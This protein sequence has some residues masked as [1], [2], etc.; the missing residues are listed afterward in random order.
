[1]ESMRRAWRAWL[2]N[3]LSVMMLACF[4]HA[5]RPSIEWV[6]GGE[7]STYIGFYFQDDRY[8]V[9]SEGFYIHFWRLSDN[10]LVRTLT[11][12]QL[13]G[14][15]LYSASLAPM[16]NRQQLVVAYPDTDPDTGYRGI[17]IR[18]LQPDANLDNWTTAAQGGSFV[19]DGTEEDEP[20]NAAALA[21]SPDGQ[22]IAVGGGDAAG[23]TRHG[24]VLYRIN[25]NQIERVQYLTRDPGWAPIFAAAFSPDG[26]W[27]FAGSTGGWVFVYKR[28]PDGTYAYHQRFIIGGNGFY[29]QRFSFTYRP[30]GKYV[31]V[32][33]MPNGI[34]EIRR[35]NPVFNDWRLYMQWQTP[36]NS[37]PTSAVNDLQFT[38]DGNYLAAAYGSS[39]FGVI[40]YDP[41]LRIYQIQYSSDP[42][43]RAAIP[44]M[45][46]EFPADVATV[47][48]YNANATE[49]I[50]STRNGDLRRWN[51]ETQEYT[52]LPNHRGRLNTLAWS[53]N[54]AKIATAADVNYSVPAQ[55]FIWDFASQSVQ[56]RI[57]HPTASWIGALAFSPNGNYIATV[58]RDLSYDEGRPIEIWDANTGDWVAFAG[59]LSYNGSGLAFSPDG[60]YLYAAARNGELKAFQ[61]GADWQT[62]TEIAQTNAPDNA[63]TPVQIA[64]SPDGSRLAVGS[65]QYVQ[66][67]RT[68]YLTLDREI[69]V[70]PA[71]ERI[72]SVAWSPDGRYIA[73]G[74]REVQPAP[75]YL[76]S[77]GDWSVRRLPTAQNGYE[78][79]SVSFTPD[80]CYVL[81]AGSQNDEGSGVN[82]MLW[83]TGSSAL[84]AQYNDET[85][86][87]IQA[88]A[89]S[90]DGR[91]IAY[92]RDDGS[93]V[94]ANN[95]FYRRAGDV[96]RD[97]CVDDAD[98]LTVLFNF[99][100]T[101][102]TA[103]LNCDGIVDDAD[104]LIVLFNFGSGC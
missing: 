58:G 84:A 86:F 69:T 15:F 66:I 65:Q 4:A 57:D 92:G 19:E 100:G 12:R 43:Y 68:P 64:L 96:N 47:A 16:P 76:I 78:I 77:T 38:P 17:R 9:T 23:F 36:N 2:L 89:F 95:P 42:D 39:A 20:G 46:V 60:Q 85:L 72:M 54:G 21:I 52:T 29:I 56:A 14:R 48:A 33:V 18:I 70:A 40:F 25:S 13:F 103:D 44:V 49:L 32:G 35:Y 102:P 83:H 88:A 24:L 50:S 1:M 80:G 99:G 51:L 62:W 8:F 3:G 67:Y 37:A 93:L 34:I 6:G 30:D 91:Y 71:S 28:Q 75:V 74:V 87:L 10:K 94:V 22:Y 61:R 45:Q 98:L 7:V 73:A 63:L 101:D 82:L 5:Q 79:Y 27:L 11:G 31:A 81:G 55:T 59:F 90:P 53:P 97:G 104:L 26:E 41:Y